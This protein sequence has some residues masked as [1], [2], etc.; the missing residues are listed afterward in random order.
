MTSSTHVA[1]NGRIV[2]ASVMRHPRRSHPN[3]LKNWRDGSAACLA[4]NRP[5]L[6]L[7]GRVSLFKAVR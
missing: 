6:C 4:V 2:L 5:E 1:A 7:F 3:F